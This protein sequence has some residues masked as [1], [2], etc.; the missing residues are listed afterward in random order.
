MDLKIQKSNWNQF[1]RFL[2]G[3]YR[4]AIGDIEDT[5]IT[6]CRADKRMA[7][8]ESTGDL[9]GL[10]LILRSVCAQNNGPVKVDVEYQNLNT[11]HSAVGFKQQKNVNKSLIVKDQLFLPPENLLL[12]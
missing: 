1:E 6:Y 5:I 2:S 4:T 3:Y 10:L 7:L 11:L 8:V 9:I 12:D